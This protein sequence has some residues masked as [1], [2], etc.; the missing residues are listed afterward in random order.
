MVGMIR[1]ASAMQNSCS[2]RGDWCEGV[3]MCET[4]GSGG[5]SL[6]VGG[7][8]GVANDEDDEV[9]DGM[10]GD[11]CLVVFVNVSSI[12]CTLFL[13]SP[14]FEGMHRGKRRECFPSRK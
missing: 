8:V 6:F 14:F 2:G 7:E 4:A 12:F 5:V 1:E 3:V 10:E 13:S 11:G 9:E